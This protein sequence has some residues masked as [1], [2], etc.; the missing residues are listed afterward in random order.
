MPLPVELPL[1]DVLLP[2]VDETAMLRECGEDA[3]SEAEP[4]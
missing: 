1:P 3:E 4:S 2:V